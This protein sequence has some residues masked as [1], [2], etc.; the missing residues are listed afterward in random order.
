[1]WVGRRGDSEEGFWEVWEEIDRRSR[2][3]R[4]HGTVEEIGR[5]GSE[6]IGCGESPWRR[7]WAT[8][9]E[10]HTLS[11]TRCLVTQVPSFKYPLSKIE[12]VQPQVGDDRT[13]ENERRV[14]E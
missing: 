12:A 5:G 10:T 1:M 7:K 3:R 14:F 4:G 6:D 2:E 13:A 8:M 9:C 11:W